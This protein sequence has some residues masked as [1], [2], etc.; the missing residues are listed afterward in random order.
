VYVCIWNSA[1]AVWDSSWARDCYGGHRPGGRLLAGPAAH[2]ARYCALIVTCLRD[3]AGWGWGLTVYC[4]LVPS[5]FTYC[6]FM[7]GIPCSCCW[8]SPLT[9]TACVHRMW[10]AVHCI[11]CNCGSCCTGPAVRAGRT[12]RL[13]GCMIRRCICSK[14]CRHLCMWLLVLLL[15][16]YGPFTERRVSCTAGR[17]GAAGAAVG[18]CTSNCHTA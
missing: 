3:G 2:S 6:T 16:W 15:C 7:F 5:L 8:Q 4:M 1:S 12:F 11:H 14:C 10:H 18:F 13:V 17:A 9:C